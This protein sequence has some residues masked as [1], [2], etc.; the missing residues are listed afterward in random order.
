MKNLRRILFHQDP[1]PHFGV[2]SKTFKDVG[3]SI[4]VVIK[5]R[6]LITEVLIWFT[7]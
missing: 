4:K 6:P 5:K 1:Q 3:K 2:N 7:K